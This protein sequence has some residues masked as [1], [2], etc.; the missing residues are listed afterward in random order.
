MSIAITLPE[1]LEQ[2]QRSFG[3]AVDSSGSEL[4]AEL[5]GRLEEL[6][7]FFLTG[8]RS[9]LLRETWAAFCALASAAATRND[10]ILLDRLAEIAR[11]VLVSRPELALSV[12]TDL[13]EVV[14]TVRISPLAYLRAM[15]NLFWSAIRHPLSE[16]TIDLSTGRVLYRT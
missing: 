12:P 2:R 14:W 8:D 3:A 16:T 15:G 11:A 10:T 6:Q 4:S 13:E 7:I 1:W 5:L 9:E